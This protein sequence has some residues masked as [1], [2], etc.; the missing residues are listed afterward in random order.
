MRKDE[1][2]EPSSAMRVPEQEGEGEGGGESAASFRDE[3]LDQRRTNG[4]GC[5]FHGDRNPFV[6][7]SRF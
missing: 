6:R 4:D 1:Q 5:G 2:P 7:R 3:E